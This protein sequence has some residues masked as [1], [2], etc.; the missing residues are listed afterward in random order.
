VAR[1]DFVDRDLAPDAY[2]D[3]PLPIGHNQ[4]I[5]QPY[6]VAKMTELAAVGPASRVLEIGVG[7][8]YQT[9]VLLE[10][11]ARV[12][13]IEIV[14]PLALIAAER[15]RWMGYT[16]FTILCRDG[17]D[18][19]REEAP[20][21]AIILAAA[22]VEIPPPLLEQLAPGGRLIAPVG[23]HEDQQLYVY[24]AAKEG[25]SRR[26]VFPVRFVPMIG[27]AEGEDKRD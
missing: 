20:F 19:L 8:G 24:T 14:E 11:G 21:S 9:A 26:T 23:P 2:E 27:R 10:L 7:S 22:P 12:F 18:G 15:L 25:I 16:D 1:E 4:T 17:Y 3:K 13:G 6:M 5:S